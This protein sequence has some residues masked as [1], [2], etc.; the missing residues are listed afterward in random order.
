MS[1]I[2]DYRTTPAS[3]NAAPPNGFPEGMAPASLNDGMRQVMAD[4]RSWYEDPA[5][6]NLGHTPTYSSGTAFILSGDKTSTYAAGVRIKASG[7]TPFTIYG[8]I[9]SASYSAP[10][11][12]VSVTWDSESMDSTLNAVSLNLVQK[13]LSGLSLSAATITT[14]TNTTANIGTANIT[15]AL[16]V[17]GSI[18]IS[19]NSTEA[20][21][22]TL[23]ED[24][25]NGTSKVKFQAPASLASDITLTLPNSSGT[26]VT[27]EALGFS[28]YYESSE[29]SLTAGTKQ[30]VSHSL[31]VQPR[32]VTVSLRCK[33][34]ELGHSVGDE[35]TNFSW[36]ERTVNPASQN[37]MGYELIASSTQ[38]GVTMASTFIT[39]LDASGVYQIITPSSWKF[40]LRAWG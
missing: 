9:A 40:V 24:T 23:A 38:V 1:G 18:A 13:S 35:V 2:K 29:L 36:R 17:V 12:T 20:A 15:T 10:N 32:L 27:G 11:T 34:A 16:N 4:I 22:I 21:F 6:I 7:T 31:G 3:N 30:M 39:I 19:G 33:T 5:W 26:L 8:T 25:D 28:N 14:L 37:N